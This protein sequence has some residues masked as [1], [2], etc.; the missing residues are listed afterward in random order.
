M[1]GVATH[2]YIQ[3]LLAGYE[4]PRGGIAWLNR[5]RAAALERANALAVPTTRDEE[6]RFTDIAPLLKTGFRPAARQAHPSL[7]DLSD[8]IAR[9][10]TLRLVF[11]DGA[12]SP[13]LS[14]VKGLPDGVTVAPLA[15]ALGSHAVVIE[16]QLGLRA[17]F[18][19]DVF[20][21]VNTAWLRDGAF[22]HV[23]KGRRCE[24]P[25]QVLHVSTQPDAVAYPRCLLVA[26]PGAECLLI[27][28]YAA[29]A[30]VAYFN[31]AVTELVAGEGARVRHVRI[32]REA[33]SAFHVA[34][35]AATVAKDAHYASHAISTGARLS[36]LNLNVAQL[37][38]GVEVKLDGLALIS[39]RQLAD[40][41]TLMD[42]LQPRGACQQMH[43][44]IVGGAAHAVFN[45]KIVVRPGAQQTDS[46][47]QSRVLLLSDRARVDAKP[48]LEIFADDV[49]C[50]HGAA[51]GQLDAEQLFYL[52]SRGLPEQRARN[53]LTYAFAAELIDRIPVPSLVERLERGVLAEAG[54]EKA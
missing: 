37:G 35:C 33:A 12:Y 17:P 36:R 31:N 8:F 45:G 52:R 40:T 38:E 47:Q 44:C 32:Q 42:H 53:L 14:L 4:A 29:T 13:E 15:A 54:V 21:A 24:A 3:S 23:A 49:K 1:T 25:I 27:E 26:E 2:P 20:A 9:E 22:I 50:A 19:H 48:Q 43:K 10:A 34:T 39:G 16:P 5:R 11:V 41:H 28:D 18:E 51:I 6:W 46:A 7:A 30:D